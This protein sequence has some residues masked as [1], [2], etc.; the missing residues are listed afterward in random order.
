[1]KRI[2]QLAKRY[3]KALFGSVSNQEHALAELRTVVEI[4]S[5][6]ADILAF[7]HSHLQVDQVKKE[8]VNTAFQGRGLS[9]ETMQ[10]LLLLA[11]K[12]RFGQI[13]EIATAFEAMVDEHNG[14][15]RGTVQSAITLNDS[16]RARLEGA[17]THFLNK[18]VILTYSEDPSLVGGV[19][20]QVAGWTFEDT[21]DSH[22]N[23]LKEDLNRRAN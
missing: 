12:G 1:V 16:S 23:R 15:I 20:A 17:I 8:I 6:D 4:V 2:S 9:A 21:L 11:E 19:L 5:Q 13:V 14:I 7:F 3:A 22:L 18:K 10:F